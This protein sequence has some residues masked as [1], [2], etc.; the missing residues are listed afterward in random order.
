MRSFRRRPRRFFFR[1]RSPRS[2]TLRR[3]EALLEIGTPEPYTI[4]SADDKEDEEYV[5]DDEGYQDLLEHFKKAY[6][7]DR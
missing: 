3:Y 4:V 5:P 6:P 7:D 2:G 1:A